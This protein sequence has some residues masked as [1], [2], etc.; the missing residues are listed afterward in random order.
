MP[1]EDR[2]ALLANIPAAN[3]VSLDSIQNTDISNTGPAPTRIHG[4]LYLPNLKL[5]GRTTI[6][7]NPLFI[8]GVIIAAFLLIK[9]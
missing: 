7:N 3:R 2:T 5:P 4:T 1:A 8:G 6:F 9:K